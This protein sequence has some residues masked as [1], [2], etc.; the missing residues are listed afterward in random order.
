VF[1]GTY[2][3]GAAA[4]AVA[5]AGWL[6]AM[7]ETEA[8][9]ARAGA[10][11]G[12]VPPEA[13]DAIA[14]ACRPER[15]DAD[16]LE[17]EAAAHATPVIGLVAALREAVG[18]PYAPFVHAGA[19]S[20]D[21]LDTAFVLIARRALKATLADARAAADAAAALAAAH[22]ETP[23]VGRTLGRQAL[24]TTFGLKAA[25]WMTALD[26]AC[27]EVARAEGQLAVQL[28]GPVGAGDPALTAALARELRLPEPVLPWHTDRTRV[29]TLGGALGT[30]AG[31]LAKVARDT[32]LLGAD[33]VGEVREGAGGRGGSSSMAHK[34]NPV[35]AIS[36]LACAG[37]VP[38]LVGTLLATMAAEHERAA[39]AWQAERGAASDLLA[40]TGSA[41]AWG[42]D[43]LEHLEIDTGRMA[44]N[45][46]LLERAGVPGAS[47]VPTGAAALVDRALAAH[48]GA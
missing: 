29:A 31:A 13:A 27:A 25:G 30:L 37:R 3:R 7:L 22:R 38:G 15:F 33:E 34:R 2:G 35:A 1:S 44:A 26:R 42:R 20:Q 46:A 18:A 11:A 43:L 4:A 47:R 6:A 5:R 24:P 28:G 48:W 17:R 14:A 41:A 21:V 9:L 32:I 39:G 40:L 10:A 12:S 45:L 23:I 19:T 36:V 8:A 16:E